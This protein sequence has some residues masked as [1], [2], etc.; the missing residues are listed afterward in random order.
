MKLINKIKLIIPVLLAVLV[1]SSC[2]VGDERYELTSYV[3]DSLADFQ[4]GS[5]AKLV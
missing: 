5:G 3:G 2:K 4:R 1:L